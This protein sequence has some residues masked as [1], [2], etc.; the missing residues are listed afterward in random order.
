MDTKRTIIFTA[1]FLLSAAATLKSVE[2][3]L[4]AGSP[5]KNEI[6]SLISVLH[7]KKDADNSHD[8]NKDGICNILDLIEL[9]RQVISEQSS[10]QSESVKTEF[11]A[12]SENVKL[13]G[14]TYNDGEV[15]WLVQSGSAAEFFV[16]ADTASIIIAGDEHTASEERYRPRYAVFVDDVLVEDSLLGAK[17]KEIVLFEGM[18]QKNSTVKIIHLSEANNGAIGIKKIVTESSAG[19]PV[20]PVPSKKY[21][22]EFIGD[23][24]TCAY[25]VEGKSS[26]DP[27]MTSTENFMKSYAY[28][29]AKKLDADYSAVSYS[30][31]GVFSGYTSSASEPNRDSLVPDYYDLTGRGY[32]YPWDFSSRKNDVVVINLGTNDDT[33]VRGDRENRAGDFTS[34]YAEFLDK[35][36]EKNPDAYIICTVGTMGCTEMY[37]PIEKAV[38]SFKNKNNDSRIMCYLSA[39]H[40]AS[41]GYGSDWHP[42]EISQQKSSYVLADVICGVLGIESDRAGID[43][44]AE[45]TYGVRANKDAG[46]YAADYIDLEYTYSMWIN[47]TSGGNEKTDVQGYIEGLKMKKGRYRLE[48]NCTSGKDIEMPVSIAQNYGDGKKYFSDVTSQSQEKSHYSK[49]IEIDEDDDNCILI[50]DVGG[51][52]SCNVTVSDISL[53][54]LS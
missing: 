17:E 5:G 54:K 38:E 40:K 30:G 20:V 29:T 4:C 37:E 42:S 35:V 24:I 22:I 23:S 25:G 36:R 33:Y 31:Y 1:A 6:M 21:S 34:A 39:T 27:F 41:D 15:T 50:F 2:S 7:G 45:G 3:V 8:I 43:F 10:V 47:I 53:V 51:T 44:A 48:F 16:S 28:L 46:A 9:K 32:E 14:R 18:T 11:D 12:V 26:S 13:T 49:E 19:N 52:D